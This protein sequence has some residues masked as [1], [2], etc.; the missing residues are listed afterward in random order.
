MMTLRPSLEITWPV[1]PSK[2]ERRNPAHL[3]PLAQRLLQCPLGKRQR[4]PR[5]LLV[6]G[7]KGHVV[8]VARHKHNLQRLARALD[9]RVHLGELGR[10]AEARR[11]PVCA[12]VQAHDL[13]VRERRHRRRRAALREELQVG[14]AAQELV[15]GFWR[16][17]SWGRSCWKALA[18]AARGCCSDCFYAFPAR[19]SFYVLITSNVQ[20]RV[21]SSLCDDLGGGAKTTCL[22]CTNI[23]KFSATITPRTDKTDTWTSCQRV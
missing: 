21:C 17:R 8:V 16:G 19:R 14:G 13:L 20:Q 3:E 23:R 7:I 4:Q 1:A 2:D 9:H 5:H 11:A 18:G 22:S 12:E 6:V 15:H 10:E